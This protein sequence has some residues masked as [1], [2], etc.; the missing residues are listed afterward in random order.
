MPTIIDCI[1]EQI[2][3]NP[4]KSAIICENRQYTFTNIGHIAT[5]ISQQLSDKG[6]KKGDRVAVLASRSELGV[7]L[8]ISIMNIGAIY[9]PLDERT[10]KNRLLDIFRSARIKILV[11]EKGLIK[12][13]LN[14]KLPFI[15]MFYSI[16]D[17]H[18]YTSADVSICL[19]KIDTYSKAVTIFTSGSTGRPKGITHSHQALYIY[20]KT[21]LENSELHPDDKLI[22][23]V[24]YCYTFSLE[25]F[26]ALINGNTLY[27]ATNKMLTDLSLFHFYINKQEITVALM[28]TQIGHLFITTGRKSHLRL[29]IIGG[30]ILPQLTQFPKYQILSDYGCSEGLFI[31]SHKISPDTHNNIL[32]KISKHLKYQI[33]DEFNHQVGIGKVGELWISGPTVVREYTD[34]PQLTNNKFVHQNGIQWY[35]TGDK[36]KILPNNTYQFA[37]RTDRMIKIG[38][39]R[40]EPF[41]IELCISKISKITQ[42]FVCLKQVN[43][44][45]YLCAYYISRN[46]KEVKGIR[47]KLSKYFPNYMIPAF[48]I[49]LRHFPTTSNGK[50]DPTQLPTSQLLRKERAFLPKEEEETLLN[51]I[52]Q[53]LSLKQKI[54]LDDNFTDIGGNSVD[55]LYLISELRKHHIFITLK[56]LL[57]AKKFREL[58]LKKDKKHSTRTNNYGKLICRLPPLLNYL[59]SHNSAESLNRFVIPEF[60]C[61][62]PTTTLK[63]LEKVVRNLLKRHD[64]LRALLKEDGFHIQDEKASSLFCLK[65]KCLDGNSN[66]NNNQLKLLIEELYKS[67]DVHNGPLF[68]VFLVRGKNSAY[69]LT[70][71]SHLISDNFSKNILK[72]DFITIFYNLMA[73][74]STL[75][76]PKISTPYSYHAHTPSYL[77][78]SK[79]KPSNVSLRKYDTLSSKLDNNDYHKVCLLLKNKDSDLVSC[80]LILLIKSWHE[81]LGTQNF[82]FILFRH[83]RDLLK[84]SQNGHIS[85]DHTVGFFPVC[86]KIQFSFAPEISLISN[87]RLIHNSIQEAKKKNEYFDFL[88]EDQTPLFGFNYLGETRDFIDYKNPF[89]SRP[90]DIPKGIYTP[91]NLD[92]GA[93]FMIFIHKISDKIILQIRYNKQMYRRSFIT[94]LFKRIKSNISDIN[95]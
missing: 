34:L 56:E 74:K 10:P 4:N 83:G 39:Q 86:H 40:I 28:P 18:D 68:A 91:N 67:I 41:E 1:R 45:P 53:V 7:L 36:F 30:G 79:H 58:I 75:P 35:K 93:P 42:S 55:A 3:I 90:I 54:G 64:M 76:L 63:H 19:N 48:F 89:L 26:Q 8:A 29:L 17:L 23:A 47:K 44:R 57:T 69:I 11:G 22:V 51:C 2:R 6:I 52:T 72:Q 60:F 71:C 73:D 25:M 65:E 78:L 92:M 59:I 62:P 13:I 15:A 66:E 61:C 14:S 81:I 80:M 20:N 31:G 82:N 9:I 37:G 87:I 27:I 32:D 88:Q 24:N 21:A 49:K 46:N 77:H 94:A 38:N 33:V 85:F 95:H 12:P 5:I 50:I 84:N 70:A 16:Y 43:M